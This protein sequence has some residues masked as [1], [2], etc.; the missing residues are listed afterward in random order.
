VV[1]AL[2]AGCSSS[3]TESGPATSTTSTDRSGVAA[4][5]PTDVDAFSPLLITTVAPDPIPVT[6]TDGKVHVAYEL[7]VLNY[8]PG[9]PR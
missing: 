8:S 2:G 3:A 4:G 6:G 7:E 9:W 5:Y 1:L